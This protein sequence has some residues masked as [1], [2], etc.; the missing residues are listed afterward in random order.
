MPMLCKFTK[1]V[2]T[3]HDPHPHDIVSNP[4]AR[5][6]EKQN[7]ES[8]K[9]VH[10]IIIL[11]N[12]DV[13]YVKKEYGKPV[14]VIPHASF[15]Y[16]AKGIKVSDE[17]KN[18][19]GFIGRIEPYNGLDLLVEAFQRINDSSLHLIIAGSGV[20][21]TKLKQTINNDKRIELINR[22]I[23]DEEFSEL[24]GRMDYVELPYKLA[25][26]SGVIPLVFS[27]GKPVIVTNVGALEEQVPDGTG[28]VV[29][30][31]AKSLKDAIVEIYDQPNHIY[32]MGRKAFE[33]ANK[34]LTWTHS[35][36]L[37]MSIIEKS[38]KQ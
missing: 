17:I 30:A 25:S 38:D 32:K 13:D 12:G 4:F 2:T 24:I 33:Y 27:H 8:L 5:Y 26:Q 10:T 11:N 28:V 7:R 6:I 35:A 19:I 14:Y 37:L 18:T 23:Q 34:E 15:S 1:I 22:Y 31:S 3:L 16:Y 36:E 9:K 29:D 21:D 20:I